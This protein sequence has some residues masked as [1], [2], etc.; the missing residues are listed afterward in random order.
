MDWFPASLPESKHLLN[1]VPHFG[2]DAV[3]E[4]LQSHSKARGRHKIA[5]ALIQL[6]SCT[7]VI[8]FIILPTLVSPSL[9]AFLR[10]YLTSV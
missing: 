10:F 9:A 8:R 1:C 3:N 2:D 5:P 4:Q 7:C 6:F